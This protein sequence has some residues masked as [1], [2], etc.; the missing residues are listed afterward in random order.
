M[1]YYKR[2]LG[3]YAK[4]TGRLTML[5][6]GAYTL[7][8]D[9]CYDRESFPTLEQA[10][11]W[12]WASTEQE[13]EAVKFVLSRFFKLGEDGQYVQ[14]RILAELLEYHQKADTNKRIAV[15][16]ETKRKQNSTN[17]EQVV[18]EP[19]PNHKPIT[20]NQEPKKEKVAIAPSVWPEWM[21]LETWYAF[22]EMRKKIKKPPTEKAVELLVAKLKK[23]KDAGQDIQSVLEKSIT[24][25]WQDVFEIKE[26]KSFAQQA[27]DVARTTVPAQ[28]TGPD[29]VLLKIEADR[30]RAAPMPAHIRQQINQVLRKV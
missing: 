29:P 7:L 12:T 5:Q 10:I 25:N 19:P 22:L 4:K 3:D 1:H 15:E 14:D 18:N 13:I 24:S 9:S 8:I 28:H 30:Q 16:R 6:H 2:N 27:A 11:D 21:P 17:R 26:N 23:F 20:I